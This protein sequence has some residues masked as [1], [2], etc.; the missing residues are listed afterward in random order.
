MVLTYLILAILLVFLNGFF[1]LAEFSA[2]KMRP[3][4]IKE[5]IDD[6]VGGS[7]AV[8]HV[9]DRMDEYLSVCQVGIT[10]ASIGLGF[11][12]E[13]AIVDLIEPVLGWTG[14]F[15]E[16]DSAAWFTKHGIAFSVSYLLVSFMHILIGELVPKS[17]AIRMT[18]K[19]S[20][21]T[22]RPLQFF[23]ALFFLP[24]RILNSSAA[25]VLGLLGLGST[26]SNDA[27]SEE[28]IRILLNQ[29][30]SDGMMTFRR[31]L[32]LE[33][34]FDLGELRVRDAM[35]PRSQVRCMSISK[36]WDEN[37]AIARQYRF[38]RYPLIEDETK[39]PRHLIHLKD[40]LL[41]E[42]TSCDLR[43][44]CRPIIA[45][46]ENA[47]LESLLAE[48][49][50]K[51]IHAAMVRDATGKWTGFLTLE[52]A[53]EE[54]IGTI[55][56][57]FEEEENISLS[58]T[59]L[60]DRIKL[61]IEAESSAEAVSKAMALMKPESLPMPKE[62]ILQAISERERIVES[63]L[64]RHLGMPHARLAGLQK[65]VVMVLR[66]LK[67]I[68]YRLTQERANLLFVLLTPAGQPRVH[69]RLQAII[70][71]LLDESDFIPERLKTATSAI[72]VLD[73][74][75]TG[76]QATLD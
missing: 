24:L 32:F 46:D 33:N 5:M 52:D 59:L 75:R 19:S 6:K 25:F 49:Q 1:V 74:L 13:P 29:S 44:L 51:R 65:P 40:M 50:K 67:G 30:Q 63:Y 35:R 23:R 11:V 36:T 37:L 31:L 41:S 38:S 72:E 68:P 60:E 15:V 10:F 7:L 4:R 70:A 64:G 20:L 12:A 22:A 9:H 76:E 45:I 73:I 14:L 57:E 28:E 62:K 55:R 2:V 66:S 42:G 61:N 39:D 26:S 27:H 34:V 54:I 48:M 17:I 43:E 69:Q 47:L 8:Q 21:W 53:I 3:S 58:E 18:E 16:H 56:D 71:T